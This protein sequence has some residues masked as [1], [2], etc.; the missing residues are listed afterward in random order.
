MAELGMEASV[1][2]YYLW[3]LSDK[4]AEHGLGQE[5]AENLVALKLL[6]D[7]DIPLSFHSDFSM[8]PVEP[9]TLAWT[10]VNRATSEGS[11]MS[12]EQRITVYEALKAITVDAARALNLEDEI[13]TLEAGKV[14]NFTILEANPLEIS[15]A[16]LKDLK[17]KAVV[18]RGAVHRN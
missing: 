3:A 13:G 18:Y 2:P 8:A 14:A 12:Q 4:Y 17:V 10:A 5:R 15:P 9:L 11:L 6:V 7:R 16:S 1:N